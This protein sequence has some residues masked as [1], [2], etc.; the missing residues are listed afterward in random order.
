MHTLHGRYIN[1]ATTVHKDSVPT[2][3]AKNLKQNFGPLILCIFFGDDKLKIKGEAEVKLIGY[4]TLFLM[5]NY[6]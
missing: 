4:S 2:V 1:K 3:F 6:R 5:D